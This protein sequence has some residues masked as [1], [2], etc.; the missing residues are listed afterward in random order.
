MILRLVESVAHR[1]RPP[2]E[3]AA[4][5]ADDRS[6]RSRSFVEDRPAPAPAHVI[7][8]SASRQQGEGRGRKLGVIR[9]SRVSSGSAGQQQRRRGPSC[10]AAR[11]CAS[12]A[13]SSDAGRLPTGRRPLRLVAGEL[14]AARRPTADSGRLAPL[15]HAQVEIRPLRVSP[16]QR[17]ICAARVQRGARLHRGVQGRTLGA[18]VRERLARRPGISSTRLV[19]RAAS[20]G[21]IVVE[22]A[23]RAARSRRS[24]RWWPRR[25]WSGPRVAAAAR[26]AGANSAMVQRISLL[27]PPVPPDSSRLLSVASAASCGTMLVILDALELEG[28]GGRG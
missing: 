12:D 2:P 20:R 19:E 22:E 10:S 17:S 16:R 27:R 11:R 24:G 15:G 18:L 25:R 7:R 8:R 14:L 5:R 28:T 9:P 13:S 4:R 1:D 21:E 3:A 23:E 26:A 6:P